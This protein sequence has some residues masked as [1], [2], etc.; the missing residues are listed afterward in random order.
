MSCPEIPTPTSFHPARMPRCTFA[1]QPQILI[2]NVAL[3]VGVWDPPV[4]RVLVPLEPFDLLTSGDIPHSD[5]CI[6]RSR[7]D[8]LAIG[9]DYTSGSAVPSHLQHGS[10]SLTSD[11]GDT[12]I[13]RAMLVVDEV[14][15][16]EVE[17]A[18][19][20]FDIP[21]P[22]GLVSRTRHQ[23]SAVSGKV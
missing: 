7:S 20:L 16:A 2:Q 13:D 17:H 10:P 15:D 14:V 4:H 6:Q 5:H 21:D 22:G 18:L 1:S 19:T 9:R 3:L 12:S 8:E 11:R 23:E